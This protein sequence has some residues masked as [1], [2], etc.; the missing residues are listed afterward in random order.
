M[1]KLRNATPLKSPL[2]YKGDI[3]GGAGA[4]DRCPPAHAR[5]RAGARVPPLLP[6]GLA[7]AR[8]M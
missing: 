6:S 3:C 4:W 5:T 8:P 7:G 1:A 2:K